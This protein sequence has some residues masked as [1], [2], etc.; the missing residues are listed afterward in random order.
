MKGGPGW[1]HG[2]T[3]WG[4]TGGWGGSGRS[5]RGRWF[6]VVERPWGGYPTRPAAGDGM[7]HDEGAG[8]AV[9]DDGRASRYVARAL[10]LALR[11]EWRPGTNR[12]RSRMGRQR[13]RCV[14]GDT[15]AER[16]TRGTRRVEKV[17]SKRRVCGDR[18]GD[19][20]EWRQDAQRTDDARAVPERQHRASRLRQLQGRPADVGR[21]RILFVHVRIRS[22]QPEESGNVRSVHDEALR[23]QEKRG[24]GAL[25]EQRAA[26]VNLGQVPN[27]RNMIEHPH[28]AP[29]SAAG[30]AHDGK[31]SLPFSN[32]KC[33]C[34]RGSRIGST[35][36][37]RALCRLW[38]RRRKATSSP[39]ET[40]AEGGGTGRGYWLTKCAF[41]AQW[42]E[43]PYWIRRGEWWAT[44]LLRGAR[45]AGR[46]R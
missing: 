36:L 3:E 39:C 4:S 1:S 14:T 38:R 21:P 15:G 2:C 20:V 18:P 29:G 37:L 30:K 5:E 12:C 43:L 41:V 6:R 35:T 17:R 13:A 7:N 16:D 32:V 44:T 10:L 45:G 24:Q 34:F 42:V 19:A 40:R 8:G 28:R 33:K 23:P 25:G 31:G 27:P 26:D 9:D 22:D 46:S 11:I